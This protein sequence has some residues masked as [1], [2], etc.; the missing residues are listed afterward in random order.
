MGPRMNPSSSGAGSV[1]SFVIKGGRE[2]GEKFANALVLHS[3]LA[4]IGDVRSLVVHPSSTTHSQL[5]DAEQEAAYQRLR[6]LLA[7]VEETRLQ[8]LA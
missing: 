4:N 2:A 6:A 8:P 7:D 1:P 3:Q 5:S